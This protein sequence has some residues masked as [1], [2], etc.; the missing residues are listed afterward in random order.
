MSKTD[1]IRRIH[2][3]GLSFGVVEASSSWVPDYEMTIQVS[4]SPIFEE[5]R[6]GRTMTNTHT[7]NQL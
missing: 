2:V 6:R 7:A 5:R 1:S 4:T 3:E